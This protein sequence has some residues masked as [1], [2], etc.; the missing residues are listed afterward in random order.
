MLARASARASAAPIPATASLA[1]KL[2]RSP[3]TLMPDL[4]ISA[5]PF[6]LPSCSRSARPARLPLTAYSGG[7]DG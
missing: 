4:L 5:I 3:L 1:P 7:H 6:A 2:L